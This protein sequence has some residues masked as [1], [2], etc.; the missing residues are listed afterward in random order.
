MTTETLAADATNTTSV[1]AETAEQAATAAVVVGETTAV[2]ETVSAPAGAPESY[3]FVAP[4]GQEFDSGIISVYSDVAKSLDLP[5]D[6]AQEMLEKMSPA[7]AARQAEKLEAVK[8][9]WLESAKSDKEYGGDK[10]AE[11]MSFVAKAR[12]DLA[13]PE[14]RDLLDKTGLGNHPEM[15]RLFY[16]YGKAVSEDTYKPGRNNGPSGSPQSLAQRM[17][18]NMNP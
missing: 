6:K 16:R 10:L 12:D 11:N 2:A 15:V 13:T 5:Q 8:A 18:P 9:E 14:L 7:I 3:S 4:E 1:G 17:Y